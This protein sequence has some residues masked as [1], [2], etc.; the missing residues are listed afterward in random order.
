MR[1]C[2]GVRRTTLVEG[3]EVNDRA[4]GSTSGGGGSVLAGCGWGLRPTGGASVSSGRVAASMGAGG[5]AGGQ[6]FRASAG[7]RC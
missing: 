2:G 3:V 6:A 5:V 4:A 7:S 1:W